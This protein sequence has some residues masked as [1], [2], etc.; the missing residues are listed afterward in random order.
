[1]RKIVYVSSPAHPLFAQHKKQHQVRDVVKLSHPYLPIFQ[2][3]RNSL[4][5]A[6]VSLFF[7][8]R[9]EELDVALSRTA[10]YKYQFYFSPVHFL[11]CSTH[12][13]R[14][15][16]VTSKDPMSCGTTKRC[17]RTHSWRVL[18]SEKSHDRSRP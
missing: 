2:T 13:S 3:K 15:P 16:K 10:G 6:H 4:A 11:P 9:K 7:Q 18:V 17:Y 5:A 1:M 14:L 12:F 8:L